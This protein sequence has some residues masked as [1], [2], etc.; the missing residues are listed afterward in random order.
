M[1]SAPEED[2]SSDDD[3]ASSFQTA[4]TDAADGDAGGGG[5][6]QGSGAAGLRLSLEALQAFG[7]VDEVARQLRAAPTREARRNMLCILLD[8][9]AATACQVKSAVRAPH[10]CAC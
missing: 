5:L 4:A 1:A 3:G 8:C 9:V 7:G 10:T 2:G 6:L